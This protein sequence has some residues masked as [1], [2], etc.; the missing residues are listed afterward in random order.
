[1]ARNR[2]A[3]DTTLRSEFEEVERICLR[4]HP[5]LPFPT[6]VLIE[7]F[8]RNAKLFPQSHFLLWCYGRGRRKPPVKPRCKTTECVCRVLERSQREREGDL[9][10][11]TL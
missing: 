10:S 9:Q 3:R 5:R 1:M 7:A 8:L 4:G 11:R 6:E 2:D